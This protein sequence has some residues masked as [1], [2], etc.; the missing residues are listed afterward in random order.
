MELLISSNISRYTEFCSVT[1]VLTWL[2]EQLELVPCSRSDVFSNSKV[3]V[4]EKRML[5]KLL[6]ACLDGDEKELSGRYT[7]NILKTNNNCFS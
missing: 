3:T 6:T 1:R 4:I 2:N 5:M 7:Y